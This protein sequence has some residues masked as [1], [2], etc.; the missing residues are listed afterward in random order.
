MSL[1]KRLRFEVFK[2]D[3]FTCQY[4]GAHPPSV[5]LEADHIHPKSKGGKNDINNLITAC[6]NCNRGKS[7][8]KLSEIPS[9]LKENLKKIK[10]KEL[11]INEYDRF[12]KTIQFKRDR[13][14]KEIV[15]IFENYFPDRTPTYKFKEGTIRMFLTKL[16]FW[17]I[18]DSIHIACEKIDDPS[19]AL[20]YFC[21]ICWRR[22]YGDTY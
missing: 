11:Q 13:Q 4:C 16:P 19:Q 17:E 2:R 18:F 3:K 7:N 8:N 5:V 9:S 12:L 14:I 15:D 22:I 21:G 6:F 20:K 1:S 10:E